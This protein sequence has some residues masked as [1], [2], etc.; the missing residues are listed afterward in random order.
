MKAKFFKK[1]L[2]ITFILSICLTP[3]AKAGSNTNEPASPPIGLHDIQ[4]EQEGK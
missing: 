1:F 4:G 2:A 3:W